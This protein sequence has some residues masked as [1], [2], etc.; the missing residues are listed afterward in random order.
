MFPLNEDFFLYE[1]ELKQSIDN[2]FYAK[3]DFGD[4]ENHTKLVILW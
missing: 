4:I 3:Q 2:T 1:N